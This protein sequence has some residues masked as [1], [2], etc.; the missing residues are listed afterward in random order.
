VISGW[1][2]PLSQ[3]PF[4]S[5]VLE[6][7]SACSIGLKDVV[8]VVA[9][10]PAFLYTTKSIMIMCFCLGQCIL[11]VVDGALTMTA[12]KA[13]VLRKQGGGVTGGKWMVRAGHLRETKRERQGLIHRSSFPSFGPMPCGHWPKTK[14]RLDFP[15]HIILNDLNTFQLKM[16]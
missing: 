4:L 1:T 2:S 5:N 12:C 14:S 11:V 15:A 7:L 8:D 16:K 13:T 9:F 3:L 6:W 10:S